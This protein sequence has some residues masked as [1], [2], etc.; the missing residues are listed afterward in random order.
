MHTRI[1]APILIC[2]IVL[3]R[4]STSVADP[5]ELPPEP[6]TC[7]RLCASQA[8]CLSPMTFSKEGCLAQCNFGHE[9]SK[10]LPQCVA[11]FENGNECLSHLNCEQW[12]QQ[13]AD[14]QAQ[15]PPTWCRAEVQ[16]VFLYCSPNNP[17]VTLCTNECNRAA[18]CGEKKE[19]D[20]EICANDCLEKLRQTLL[21]QGQECWNASSIAGICR[22][23]LSCRDRTPAGIA[24]LC[25]APVDEQKRLCKP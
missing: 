9:Q 19:S 17:Q 8:A 20:F 3:F 21:H 24:A 22:S 6:T 16:K 4:V 7:E 23:M 1:N 2:A 10:S 12:A 18:Q 15:R 5:R 11:P 14:L 25:R 13:F